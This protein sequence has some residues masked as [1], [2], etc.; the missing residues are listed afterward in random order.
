MKNY[1]EMLKNITKIEEVKTL[2]DA[3]NNDI[4]D[5]AK[6]ELNFA[7]LEK[8]IKAINEKN[9]KAFVD[10]FLVSFENDRKTALDALLFVPC[11]DAYSV[12]I[13]KDGTYKLTDGKR[14]FKFAKLEKAFQLLKSKENDKNG[15]PIPNTGATIFGALRF[16][17]LMMSF[18][19]N[20]QKTNFEI[21]ENEGYNLENVL[22]DEKSVF[23]K[24]DGDAFKSNSNTALQ[25]QVNIIVKIMGYDVKLIKKDLPVL[26]LQ[27]QKIRQDKKNA[28][29]S[30]NA[31]IDDK[32]VLKFADVIFGVIASRASGKDIEIVTSKPE[33]DAK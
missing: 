24:S 1:A 31:I 7:E 25:K 5:N 2:I 19:R 11:F 27:A 9:E 12:S 18:I 26:R 28:H 29:F 22:L 14:L 32:A 16:Y 3:I 30:V 4:K 10:S 21:D 33:K 20:L 17:G 8:A 6:F 23:V 15:K 13:E